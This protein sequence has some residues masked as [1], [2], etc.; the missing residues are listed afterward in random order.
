[1]GGTVEDGAKDAERGRSAGDL[2]LG[3]AIERP[4][5]GAVMSGAR[6]YR[7]FQFRI[8]DLLALMVMVAFLGATSRLPVSPFQIIP[9]FPVL[10][11][12][13]FRILSLQVRPWLSLV[14]YLGAVA[15]LLPYLYARSID[16]WNDPG[17]TAQAIWIG[18]PVYVFTVPTACFLYDVLVRKQRSWTF[19]TIRSL[20]EVLFLVPLWGVAWGFIV[21]FVL[22][23]AAI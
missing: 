13:K 1:M 15:A 2:A 9:V 5:D 20:V 14:L 8:A 22:E 17:V 21:L 11:L 12:V 10:Y 23:W 4:S 18:T 6:D 19:Y 7:R 16:C 3:R